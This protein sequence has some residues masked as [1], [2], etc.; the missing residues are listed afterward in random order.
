[1]DWCTVGKDDSLTPWRE[2]IDAFAA[3]VN[4]NSARITVGRDRSRTYEVRGGDYTVAALLERIEQETLGPSV[5][6]GREQL[7]VQIFLD[8]DCKGKSRSQVFHL[9]H[10]GQPAIQAE[11]DRVRG[12][13]LPARDDRDGIR[14]VLTGGGGQEMTAEVN[15]LAL[16]DLIYSRATAQLDDV[17]S[18]QDAAF[19]RAMS[20]QDELCQRERALTARMLSHGLESASSSREAELAEKALELEQA[21]KA[22]AR[23]SQILERGVMGLM[24][25]AQSAVERGV[26]RPESA[27]RLASSIAGA[28]AAFTPA[29]PLD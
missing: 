4:G 10:P 16:V 9:V 1:M 28:A 3:S 25:V 15:L 29:T 26:L 23:T 14:G 17:A 2:A 11:I 22:S 19:R 12:S 18:A 6:P 13:T 5:E 7:Q 20:W 21:D 8:P 27:E 24:G